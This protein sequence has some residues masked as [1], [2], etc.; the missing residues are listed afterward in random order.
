MVVAMGVIDK[1]MGWNKIM[2]DLA[3]LDGTEVAAGILKDSGVD[4]RGT[5]YTNIA[6]YNEYGTKHI[7]AR[8]AVRIAADTKGNEWQRIAEKGICDIID[9]RGNKSTTCKA[10]GEA[11]KKDIQSIFGDT[12]KLASNAPSTIRKKGRNEPL[13]DTGTLKK[14]VAYRVEGEND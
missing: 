11:M 12:S 8:P 13:V 6:I 9:G 1:D 7:P 2:R 3:D 10:V 14:K 5:P 4:S